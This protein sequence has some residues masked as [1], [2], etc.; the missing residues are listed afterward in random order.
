M[1]EYFAKLPEEERRKAKNVPFPTW[2]PPML[3]TLTNKR[4]SDNSWVYEPKFDG[5]RALTFYNQ[6][7]VQ[8]FS[9]NQIN[10]KETYPELKTAFNSHVNKDFIVDG[11][12][13]AFEK[14]ISS[15]SKLQQ[16]IG[17]NRYL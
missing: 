16:R 7:V 15:F 17:L 4:F 6:G 12:I 8:I 13:V 2:Y 9:R 14:G 3:A 10:L 5:E 11:E 1:T